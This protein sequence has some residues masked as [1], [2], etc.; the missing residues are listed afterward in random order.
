LDLGE[1]CLTVSLVKMRSVHESLVCVAALFTFKVVV[2][3]D[4][5]VRDVVIV[6][7]G[8]AGAHAAVWLRDHN[9]SVA[10][11]EKQDVLVFTPL[12]SWLRLPLVY[13]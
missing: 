6:G 8:A 12:S 5:V 4:T 11:I 1:R 7:G 13:H 9:K 2:A 10:V 3:V